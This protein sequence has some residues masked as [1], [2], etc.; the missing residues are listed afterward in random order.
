MDYKK[1]EELFT[2]YIFDIIGPNKESE[3]EREYN[4]DIINSI[5]NNALREPLADFITHIIPYGSFPTKMY[6][7]DADIDIT[8]CFESKKE[9]E[10]LPFIPNDLQD[11]VISLIKE[12]LEKKNK[13]KDIDLITDIKIIQT[14]TIRLLKCKVGNIPVDICINNFAGIHKIIF[15]EFIEEQ[16]S[17]KLNKLKIYKN[18]S[19]SGNKRNLFRRT[20]LLIK[21]WCLYEG[22]LLGSNMSLMASYTLE[23]LVIYLFNF[24][25]DE[26][27]NEF[28]GFEKF[29]EI[30]QAFQWDKEIISLFGYISNFDFYKKLKNHND[31]KI[32]NGKKNINIII[33]QPL[34]YIDDKNI[35]EKNCKEKEKILNNN[36]NKKECLLNLNDVKKFI[37]YLNKGFEY[38]YFSNYTNFDKPTNVLDPLNSHN[39]LGKSISIY[40]K[41]KMKMVISYMTKNLKHI[42]ELRKKSNPFLYMNSLLNLFKN[43]LNRFFKKFSKTPE[44]ITNSKIY[45]KFIKK[46]EGSF[47]VEKEDIIKFNSLYIKNQILNENEIKNSEEEDADEYIENKDDNYLN[48]EQ[49]EFAKD[50]EEEDEDLYEEDINNGDNNDTNEDSDN[51]NYNNTNMVQNDMDKFKFE[52]IL[53]KEI[54]NKLFEL[55]ENKINNVKLNNA[56]ILQSK[57][58]STE[59]ENFLKSHNLI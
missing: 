20:F 22:N 3:T 31:Y 35:E 27:N 37:F 24:Y 21:G 32:K 4:L 34:W 49:S 2:D 57:E 44:F 47:M 28:E 11:R 29:F 19:Y 5:I 50:E 41:S 13:E 6:L 38:G 56:F 51:D 14:D 18:N 54:L 45:K 53:N 12:G 46:E 30:M 40:N 17:Y 9:R 23:I 59:L 8:I 36:T 1:I 26:I 16:I 15:M 10:I 42:G 7:K 52:N 55:N 39:N 25:Y 33:N 48:S 58:Y 43:S